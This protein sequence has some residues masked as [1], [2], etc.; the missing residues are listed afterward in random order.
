MPKNLQKDSFGNG[1]LCL[2]GLTS[3]F[4]PG[5]QCMKVYFL[6]EKSDTIN[7]IPIYNKN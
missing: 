6:W 3:P 1:Y 5:M 2:L 7:S 4:S